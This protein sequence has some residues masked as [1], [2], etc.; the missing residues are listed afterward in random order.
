MDKLVLI[1]GSAGFIGTNLTSQLLGEGASVIG[2]DNFSASERFKATLHK[3]NPNYEFL[4]ADICQDLKP[5]LAKSQLLKK[6]QAGGGKIAEIYNLACPASP[7]RYLKLPLETIAVSTQG[8]INVLE[9]A[10]EHGSKVLHASTSEIYGDPEV[11]P[12]VEGYRGNVNTIGPRS[13]YDEGKRLAETICYEYRQNFGV[14]I[15]LV[16][17]F[18]TYGPFMD[19]EDGRVIT[20]FVSQALANIPLTIYGEGTQTRSFQFVSDLLAGIEALMATEKSFMG[21]VNIGNPEEFTMLELAELVLELTGSR[22]ELVRKTLP[23]DDPKQRRPDIS[24]A[25]EKLGW[26]PQVKLR[27]GLARTVEYYRDYLRTRANATINNG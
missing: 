5:V 17:I 2:V 19:P 12:Q 26:E 6:F 4:E 3:D 11:H 7:P 10:R 1:T 27:D 9:L 25:K 24:L 8:L 22:V 14:D 20:N 23:V 18:N 15:K 13:C 21:P 16:R